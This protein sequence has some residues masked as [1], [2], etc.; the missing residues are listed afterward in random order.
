MQT[1]K[2]VFLGFG[3]VGRALAR[4]LLSKRQELRQD[5]IKWRVV[6]IA[7]ARHGAALDTAG[8]PLLQA[9]ELAQSGE[10]LA[11][12]SK[13]PAPTDGVPFLHASGAD[14]LFENTPVNYQTGQPGLDHIRAALQAGM[15]AIT[16]NKGPLVHGYQELTRLA[17]QRGRRFLFESTVMDGAPIFSLWRRALPL[18]DLRSFRGILN[19]TT[20]LILT[21]MEQDKSY[22]QAVEHAQAIG[23]A[24]TDPRGDTQGW[25]AAIKVAAL[26]TV[27]MGMP[28]KP[29]QVRR[30]GI[31]ELD[32]KAVA[33][34][35]SEG[36]RWKLIC[37][38]ER[39]Q[40]GVRTSVGPE[41]VDRDDPL[42]NIM[43]TSSA[44][45]FQCDV[46]GPLTIIEQD[47]GPQTTAYGLLADFVEI[48]R[49]A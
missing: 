49:Q 43:G 10:N 3:N 8:I 26:T 40:E 39:T 4:L 47:P 31:E 16:A 15:H 14:M 25:D 35:L 18:A 2:L 32:P 20:N 34:A 19:S 30:Q 1:I 33:D 37:R 11:S 5:G 42:Y 13:T 29:D 44:V 22:Q 36:K 28:L 41:R 45:T 23:I 9:L 38:A 7:T 12:L 46:L 21:L 6:G 24:E 48:C 27:L 17:K